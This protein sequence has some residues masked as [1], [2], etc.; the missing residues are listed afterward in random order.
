MTSSRGYDVT[1]TLALSQQLLCHET[2]LPIPED[3]S[4][5]G[6][7]ERV[8]DAHD[9]EDVGPAHGAG[10][11]AVFVRLLPAHPPHFITVPAIRVDHAAQY[12]TH[13]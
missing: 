10:P 13:T 2:V 11:K 5:E 1:F 8:Q 7:D 6:E 12:Q 3:K 4:Q 9:G